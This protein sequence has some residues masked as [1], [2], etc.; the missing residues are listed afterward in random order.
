MKRNVI[1]VFG[2]IAAQG[3]HILSMQI[4]FMQDILRLEPIT[5]FEWMEILVL[6]VPILLVMEAFKFVNRKRDSNVAVQP[7]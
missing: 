6:A 7:S 5:P 4:P 1:L 2:V 3:I